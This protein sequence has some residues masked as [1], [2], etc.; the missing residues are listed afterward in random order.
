MMV[1]PAEAREVPTASAAAS[2]R[3]VASDAPTTAIWVAIVDTAYANPSIRLE[4]DLVEALS[5]A[6]ASTA[7]PP[8]S[9][10][11]PWKVMSNPASW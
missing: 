3:A 10:H 5:A 8:Q 1:A 9:A 11:S 2:A 4:P 7:E 6:Q